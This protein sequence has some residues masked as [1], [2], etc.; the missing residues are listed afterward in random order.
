MFLPLRRD[1]RS[2]VPYQCPASALEAVRRRLARSGDSGTKQ[3]WHFPLDQ[4]VL[5]SGSSPRHSPGGIIASGSN[6][7]DGL[8]V[9][10]LW[11]IH[12]QFFSSRSLFCE[13]R[14]GYILRRVGVLL[15]QWPYVL[16]LTSISDCV[17]C[18]VSRDQQAEI[19]RRI[20]AIK[21]QNKSSC[22][23]YH[24]QQK[25]HIKIL[26]QSI[27]IKLLKLPWIRIK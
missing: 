14:Q 9:W 6:H 2:V 7:Y 21:E 11:C 13:E 20:L 1:I 10:L 17:H 15:P 25:V 16:L 26:F 24:D 27:Q 3:Q 5:K 23:S 19:S 4:R 12:W 18:Q 8:R 22:K